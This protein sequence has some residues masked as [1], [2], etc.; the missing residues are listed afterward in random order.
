MKVAKISASSPLSPN[1][2]EPRSEW[3]LLFHLLVRWICC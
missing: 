3:W 1:S 2:C